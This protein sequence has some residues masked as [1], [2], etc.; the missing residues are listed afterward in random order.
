MRVRV[1]RPRYPNAT[2]D[3]V[4]R[5]RPNAQRVRSEHGRTAGRLAASVA[6]IRLNMANRRVEAELTG[7]TGRTLGSGPLSAEA[8]IE[9]SAS[10]S[11]DQGRGAQQRVI[12]ELR[13][14]WRGSGCRSGEGGSASV[15]PG[16][17]KPRSTAAPRS[18]AAPGAA[19][20]ERSR[21]D[22]R[23]RGG[24]AAEHPARLTP[25]TS[26]PYRAASAPAIA[27]HDAA[28]RMTQQTRIGPP[29]PSYVLHE[30]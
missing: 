7:R 28:A 22:R 14:S 20:G 19:E 2:H 16:R 12:E 23:R 4:R 25:P 1:P 6:E 21:P 29:P 9:P 8:R 26:S 30:T 3:T 27:S 18:P 15:S 5:K 13:P 17:A 24:G 10:A 11:E